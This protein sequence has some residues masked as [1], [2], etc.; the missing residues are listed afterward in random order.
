VEMG[1]KREVGSILT[2]P[3]ETI[4]TAIVSPSAR[5]SASTMPPINVVRTMGSMTLPTTSKC[6]APRAK[7]D[8]RFSRGT[9][10]SA[11]SRVEAMIGVIIRARTMLAASSPYPLPSGERW[12]PMNGMSTAMPHRPN[13]TEGTTAISSTSM[14]RTGRM[15][16]GMIS[17]RKMA[18]PMAR[19]TAMRMAMAEEASVPTMKTRMP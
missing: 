16:G 19:G 12:L 6:V 18:A 13:T 1:E 17:A 5:P 10:I 7:A 4:N 8:S 14:E 3:P 11:S 15:R 2:P 9:C